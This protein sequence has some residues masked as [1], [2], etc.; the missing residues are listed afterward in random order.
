MK[1]ILIIII[2][3]I[4]LSAS[5]LVYDTLGFKVNV[6]KISKA[7]DKAVGIQITF[8]TVNKKLALKN[9]QRKIKRA[10][11]E[12]ELIDKLI[13]QVNDSI[14]FLDPT[15]HNRRLIIVKPE[16]IKDHHRQ[17]TSL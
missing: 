4:S 15:Y 1:I 10:A 11:R 5:A 6:P 3:F 14:I 8:D 17:I 7:D 2:C 16:F 9:T 12:N 13:A